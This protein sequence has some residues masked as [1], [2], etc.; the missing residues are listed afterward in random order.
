MKVLVAAQVL[1][2]CMVLLKDRFHNEYM[3]ACKLCEL[4]EALRELGCLGSIWKE[5]T[6]RK[7]EP[8]S[9]FTSLI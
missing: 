8:H 7:S 6:L 9:S 2:P 5:A 1:N 3:N 4:L